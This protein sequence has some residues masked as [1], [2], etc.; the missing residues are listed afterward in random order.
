[1]KRILILSVVATVFLAGCTAT[2][3]RGN[4]SE[5]PYNALCELMNECKA[6]SAATGRNVNYA[7]FDYDN[8]TVLQD[9]E[10]TLTLWQLENLRFNFSPDELWDI[11]APCI[12][13]LDTVL[14]DA[15]AENV[16]ARMLLTD[17]ESDYRTMMASAGVSCGNELSPEQLAAI[18]TGDALQDFKAKFWGLLEG[19]METFSYDTSISLLRG[20]NHYMDYD[21]FAA[22]AREGIAAQVS[23]KQV[24]KILLESPDMGMAGKVSLVVPDGLA[25]TQDMRNL[26]KAL[27]ENGIDVYI[28]SASLEALVEQMACD[29]RYL[30]LDTLQVFGYRM[31]GDSTGNIL[32]A[33]KPGYIQPYR[34]GKT[35]AIKAYIAPQY[36]GRGPVLVA[37]DSNGDYSMLTS[38]PDMRVGLIIDKGQSLGGIADLRRQALEAE[39]AGTHSSYV[40]QRRADPKP[41]FK[42]K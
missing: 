34:E 25:L 22:L 39:S 24:S 29:T 2:M 40:L 32:Q 26:Y 14:V 19:V 17:I 16:T 36:D 38:F 3:P 5:G 7:I 28:F 30:G 10:Q 4:W 33:L 27:P 37:G 23:K 15:G 20:L 13:D 1:M 12:P 42:R 35:E 11:F 18:Q 21:E 8:T 6:E 41:S 31:A 9:V